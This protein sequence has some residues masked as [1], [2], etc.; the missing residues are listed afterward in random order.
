MVSL[1]FYSP[2]E[3]STTLRSTD[4]P[5]RIISVLGKDT[6]KAIYKQLQSYAA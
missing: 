4:V 3:L 6:Y 1:G 2:E 5:R